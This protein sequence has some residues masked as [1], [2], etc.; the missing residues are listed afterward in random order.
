MPKNKNRA[1]FTL[2]ELLVVIAII[3]VLAGVVVN[4]SIRG[5]GR[6]RDTRRIQ[7]LYQIAHALMQYETVHKEFPG[8]QDDDTGLACGAGWDM[9]NDQYGGDEFLQILLDEGFLN[10]IPREWNGASVGGIGCTYRYSKVENP[11]SCSGTYA[12][13]YAAC[14]TDQCPQGERPA[15]CGNL[16]PQLSGE[17][18]HDIAVFLKQE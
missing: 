13:L 16:F 17:D 12:I 8:N 3:G 7:E 14:E 2:L 11:C 15:C 5:A 18:S 9:G 4:T 6:A 10:S 1:G